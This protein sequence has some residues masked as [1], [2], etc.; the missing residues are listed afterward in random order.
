MDWEQRSLFNEITRGRD[1]AKQLQNHLRPS[2][3]AEMRLLLVEKIICSYKKA[4]SMLMNSNAF[5]ETK[6]SSIG[7]LQPPPSAANST[8]AAS[9][10]KDVSK[11][12]KTISSW[13]E[14]V[15]VCSKSIEGAPEE[16]HCWRKYGQK[17]IV[18]AKFPRGYYRCTHR[19]SQGCLATKQV[20]DIRQ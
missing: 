9:N 19:Y 10:K 15:K 6:L 12:R 2:S 11:K 3:S 13:T 8:E 5:P 1:L 4:L 18:G 16:G 7:M 20:S 17:N 14:H